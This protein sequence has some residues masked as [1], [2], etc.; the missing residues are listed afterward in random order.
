M[1]LMESQEI[2][3]KFNLIKNS[4]HQNLYFIL[5]LII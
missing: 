5:I 3:L 4:T 2:N 1:V